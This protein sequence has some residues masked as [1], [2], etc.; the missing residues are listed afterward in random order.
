MMLFLNSKLNS[1][2]AHMSKYEPL[3][4]FLKSRPAG[5]LPMTFTEVESVLGFPLPPSARSY[6]AWWSNNVGTNVAV[7]SW[8]EAGWK[9]S[10]VDVPGER[11]TFVRDA[12]LSPAT[13]EEAATAGDC[14]E[15]TLRRSDLSRSAWRMLEELAEDSDAGFAQAA[16]RIIENAAQARR[17]ELISSFESFAPLEANS[18][19]LIREDRDG[20]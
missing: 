2:E 6:P 13:Q 12:L 10:R 8:R 4:K 17:R 16:V 20:R 11:V 15:F 1:K 5:E 14:S 3:S 19:S 9:T 18:V 7:R